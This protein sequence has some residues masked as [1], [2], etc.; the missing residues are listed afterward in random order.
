[1]SNCK[2]VITR[3]LSVF[4]ISL[5][6]W[7]TSCENEKKILEPKV[8]DIYSTGSVTGKVFDICSGQPIK[9]AVVEVG[10]SGLTSKVITDENGSFSFKNLPVTSYQNLSGQL[11]FSGEYLF[12][13]SLR[14]YNLKA[15]NPKDKYR[16]YYY[17]Q[18][19][20]KYIKLDSGA[21]LGLTAGLNI[22]IG[23]LNVKLKGKVVDENRKPVSKAEVFINDYF[24]SNSNYYKKTETNEEGNFVFENIDNGLTFTIFARTKD[25]SKRGQLY[26]PLSLP[27][28]IE[29]YTLNE[30]LNSE[31]IVLYPVDN[32]NPYV[33]SISPENGADVDPLNF[34]IVCEFSEPIRQDPYTSIN[35]SG[36]GSI[37]DDISLTYLG[38]KKNLLSNLPVKIEWQDNYKKLLII[39]KDQ[40][41]GGAR[42]R[43]TIFAALSKLKDLNGNICVNNLNLIGDFEPLYF[44]TK[45]GDPILPAPGLT[46]RIGYGY[47]SLDYNG[48]NFG[49]RIEANQNVVGFNIY[50]KIDNGAWELIEKN[51]KSFVYESSTGELF[52]SQNNIPFKAIKQYFRVTALNRDLIESSYSQTVIIQDEVRPRVINVQTEASGDKHIFIVDFSE[53]ANIADAENLQNYVFENLGSITVNKIRANYFASPGKYQAFLEARFNGQIPPNLILR[54]SGIRDLNDNIMES[55]P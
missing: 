29:E 24:Y 25:G 19:E 37:V 5:L 13:I 12:T 8:D 15:T 52:V 20:I 49:L 16:D 44:T 30:D 11:I 21:Y 4:L 35:E 42:F 34:K 1:M 50:R 54:I 10:Y 40:I 43:L 31:T 47:E 32:I 48:G 27:C 53:P 55:Y 2:K 51:Y 39:P 28:N 46:R 36:Y 14:D 9:G 3:I 38:L 26:S 22:G 33:I 45:A 7:A 23:K 41:P 18:R 6:F 17:A